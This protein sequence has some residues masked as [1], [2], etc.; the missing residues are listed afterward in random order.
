MTT[1]KP[2]A[3]ALSDLLQERELSL[4]QLEKLT[5]EHDDRVSNVMLSYLTRGDMEPSRRA[6][7]AVAKALLIDPEFFAEFR[8]EKKRDELNWRHVGLKAALKALGE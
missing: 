8:L 5:A 4:R 1:S 7:E 3:E 2:F 6:M